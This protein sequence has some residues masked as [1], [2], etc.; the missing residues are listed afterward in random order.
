MSQLLGTLPSIS[1]L[2]GKPNDDWIDRMSH[3]YTAVILIIFTVAVSSGQFFKDPIQCWHPAEFKS[4][5][6][7]Y[8]SYNC[9]VKNTY[10]IPMY[11][12]IPPDI[13]IRQDAEITYYQWVPLILLLMAMLFKLPNVVWR[14]FSGGSGLNLD[15]IVGLAENS[16]LG[17]PDDRKET[18]KSIAVFI[19]KWLEATKE[20]NWTVKIQYC[21]KYLKINNELHTSFDKKLCVKF[22]EYYMRDDGVFMLRLVA[23]NSTEMVVSDLVKELWMMYKNKQNTRKNDDAKELIPEKYTNNFDEMSELLGFVPKISKLRGKP[24]DDWIDRMSHVYTTVVLIIFTVAVSSGQF[25]KDP[26]QCWHPAE[27]KDSMEAYT[28]YHCWVKN[29]YYVPM[30]DEIPENISERQDAEITYYQ[31]VPLILLFMAF[32]FKLPNVVW[33]IFNGGSGLNLDKIVHF[34]EQSQLGNPDDREKSIKSL[35]N[36]MDK[37]LD[38]NVER[39]WNVINRTKQQISRYFCFFCNKKAGKYLVALYLFVKVLYVFNAIGQIFLLNA[40]LSTKFSFYGFE[41][42]ENLNSDRPWRASP[43]FPRVTLCDFQIRQLQNFA[44]NYMRDDG[45]FVLRVIAKNSTDLVVTDLVKELYELYKNKQSTRKN[46]DV[47]EL[48][49]VANG[50]DDDIKK[51]L[52]NEYS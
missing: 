36:F 40:F 52:N 47:K 19:D 32:L 41:F 33:R 37:W 22:A 8:T 45:V 2:R 16:Q 11:D 43:R 24:N 50:D 48:E 4:S 29:T 35:A 18:I 46:E 39:N 15:K 28:K 25:F 49:P 10:Y 13:T 6:E 17:S 20:T 21:K 3:V 44:E 7:S 1:Q 38:S 5:M 51:P 42:L 30:Y 23:K 34:A 27:F 31:W 12:E 26:I 14:I 9:W